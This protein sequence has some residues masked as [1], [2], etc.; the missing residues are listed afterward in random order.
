MSHFGNINLS[1]TTIGNLTIGN[2]IV[3][4]TTRMRFGAFEEYILAITDDKARPILTRNH[5]LEF[6]A[7]DETYWGITLEDVLTDHFRRKGDFSRTVTNVR[8]DFAS[9]DV[10]I[11]FQRNK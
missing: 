7:Y 6:Q 9:D 5:T 1:N 10:I 2:H 4:E 8:M 3:T 11:T